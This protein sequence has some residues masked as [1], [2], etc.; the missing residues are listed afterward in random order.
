MPPSVSDEVLVSRIRE[1]KDESAFLQL[2]E[3]YQGKIYGMALKFTGHRQ[4][5]EDVTQEVFLRVYAKLK[6][7]RGEARFSTWLYRVASNACYSHGRGKK[8][9]ETKSLE[10]ELPRFKADGHHLNPPV[11]WAPKADELLLRKEFRAVLNEAVAA[12]PEKVRI[13]FVLRDIEG[14]N[15]EETAAILD[16]SIEAVKSRLHRARLMVRSRLSRYLGKMS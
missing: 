3:R 11:D 6:Y 8:K 5:A 1:L 12:L 9:K 10:D 7:F 2:V 13:V 16:L 15:N 14:N 4:D